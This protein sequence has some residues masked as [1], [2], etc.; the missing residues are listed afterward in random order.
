MNT[1][2]ETNSEI[3]IEALKEGNREAYARFVTEY[4]DLVYRLAIKMLANEQDA[5]DV[6]QETFL[7]AFRYLDTFKGK[8]SLSTWLYRIATN[9]A[10]MMIRKRRPEKSQIDI[11]ETQEDEG[12]PK[13]DIVDWG[14][15][16]EDSLLTTESIDTLNLEVQKLSPA[17]RIVFILRDIQGLSVRETSEV[18]DLTESAVKT[19]LSR[20]RLKLR[21]AL[22]VY[23]GQEPGK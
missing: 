10:L 22:S 4:S 11:E 7:K 16:P 19:R 1:I 14:D 3:S 18:L 17:L 12:L 13:V 20:A 15:R 23:F 5:E 2:K 21:Q 8:S 6:L 9:E